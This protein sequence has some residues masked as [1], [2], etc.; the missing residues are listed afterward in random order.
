MRIAVIGA[1]ISGMTA[2]WILS[3]R[4]E[5]SLFEADSR[6]GGHT[7]TVPVQEGK[8]TI[9]VDTGFI[10]FN[11]P[12]YPNLCRL[13]DA[14]DVASHPSDM[15]FSVGCEASG[16]EYNPSA[17]PS[18]LAGRRNFRRL[19]F[20]RMLIDIARFHRDAERRLDAAPN[21]GGIDD[22]LSVNDYL[23]ESSYGE[24]F[25]RHYFL[26]LGSS[27]WSC[28]ASK[29]GEFPVRFVLEF[30]RNHAMLRVRNRPQWRCVSGGSARYIPRLTAAY[31]ERLH[32]R[33]EVVRVRRTARGVCLDFAD[34][35]REE[36]DE[37]VIA[38][39]ADQALAMLDNPEEEE[40]SVLRCF[41]YQRNEAVL[42][43][44]TRLLPRHPRIRAAWNYRIPA[45]GEGKVM[46]SYW[47]NRLQRFEAMRDYC[48][49]L[50]PGSAL[51]P[52]RVIRRFDY[53]HPLFGAGTKEAQ[54]VR[55]RFVR[56]RRLSFCGAWWG[57]GF[58]ED[59]VNS[60]LEVAAGFGMGLDR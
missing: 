58:H 4:H 9:A 23:R 45:A 51:D 7:S 36:F 31:K 44:D 53:A 21:E 6:A 41:P 20:W 28:P 57:A 46:I 29:F 33:C 18:L 52:D 35:R 14:L 59:G 60:A 27:L 17:L 1:G 13:F 40:S 2:A 5:V 54:K 8:R 39:H 56:R 25:A 22:R 32:L 42:H 50:N 11:E 43:T 34:R 30:L 24:A 3:K 47:M 48:V 19:G 55:D 38:V 37:A 26:P 16:F 49:T 12:N 10:V 15:S